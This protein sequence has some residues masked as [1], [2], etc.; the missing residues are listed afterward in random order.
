MSFADDMRKWGSKTIET[1]E[2]AIIGIR[3]KVSDS[4]IDKD[5]V[6]TTSPGDGGQSK[7]SWTP[8][9]GSPGQSDHS[10]RDKD[11]SETKNKAHQV[12]KTNIDGDFYLTSTC[13]Y[14]RV[15]E[16]GEF[17]NP[18]KKGTY[19]KGGQTKDGVSG[20]GYNI[21]S[22]GGFSPQAPQGMVR[23]TVADFQNIVDDIVKG[24]K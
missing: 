9:T 15:L 6:D 18:P 17:P 4:I 3:S 22:Q 13:P 20:P 12:A 2:R 23:I 19:L 14:I 1:S 10:A 5:P 11:G 16:Y 24:L 7:A 21:F 8:T